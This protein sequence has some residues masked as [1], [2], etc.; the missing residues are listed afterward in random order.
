MVIDLQYDHCCSWLG[1]CWE[2]VVAAGKAAVATGRAVVIA[3]KAGV[4]PG[5]AEATAGRAEVAAG[6]SQRQG[7]GSK[8]AQESAAVAWAH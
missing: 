3:G 8:C 1:G 2:A 7:S 5:R 6:I 4:P